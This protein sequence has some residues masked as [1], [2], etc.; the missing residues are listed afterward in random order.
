T[1]SADGCPSDEASQTLVDVVSGVDIISF[2]N[3]INVYPNPNNGNFAV[4]IKGQ[5]IAKDL[6]FMLIDVT[7]KSIESRNVAFNS[8]AK[9]IYQLGNLSN[10]VYFLRIQSEDQVTILKINILR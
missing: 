3:E 4:E 10:G 2:I 1:A 5:S 9:E 6:N 7:G 8:Y